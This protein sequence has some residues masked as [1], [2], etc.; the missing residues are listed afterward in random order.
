VLQADRPRIGY[1]V[2]SYPRFS[3]TFIVREVLAREAQG[4]DVVIASLRA[5]VDS[6]FHDLVSRVAAPV[7]WIDPDARSAARLWD[8]LEKVPDQAA[9][10]ATLPALLA[11]DVGVAA[12]AAR[13]A[14]WVHEQRV[15]HL[16]AHFA[17]LP[18][19]TARLAARLAGVTYSVTAHA[20]DI[21]HSDVDQ[22]RLAAV[23]HDAD[24]VVTV[25]DFNL[26]Y[27][28]ER[29]PL[30]AS[31]IHRVYNGLDL[32]ELRYAEPVLRPRNIAAVGRL[33][34]KKGFDDLLE[35]VA[36]L[37][38]DGVLLHLDVAGT[39]PCEDALRAQARACGIEDTVRFHGPMPQHEVVRLLRGS[40]AFAAPCVVAGD[41]D[42]D[43]LPTVLLEAM[44][45]GTPCVSTPVTGI[46]EVVRDGTGLLVPEH[47]PAALAK[48]L[49]RLLDDATLRQRL[50]RGARTLLERSFDV[51]SQAAS[52]RSLVPIA[53]TAVA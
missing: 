15:D 23:L 18:G 41:G 31:R 47:D 25:S 42:R 53:R 36:L 6:R 26:R 45:V 49:R 30:A 22:T 38:A 8:A 33:V 4:E 9:L 21:F 34:P 19:R 48:A 32:S 52:L 5:T 10:R 24:H 1:V 7:S 35:A 14:R 17:S 37:R 28:R 39:G 11:E 46:P 50:A 40:A 51:T 16:H 2:K 13:L 43:G 29:H 20:K 12:Q 3:E 27:L 44:A